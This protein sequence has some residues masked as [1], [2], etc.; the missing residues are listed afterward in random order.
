MKTSSIVT[1]DNLVSAVNDQQELKS[2]VITNT[3]NV[4][5]TATTPEAGSPFN[6]LVIQDS[7]FHREFDTINN[8][9]HGQLA[10]RLKIP[11]PYYDRMPPELR[12]T[13]VNHWLHESKEKRL[14][15]CLGNT[16]RA[17][18]SNSYYCYDHIDILEAVLPVLFEFPNMK[19]LSCDITDKKLYL[20]VGFEGMQLEVAPG[21]V[22]ESGVIISNSE[23]GAGSA[24]VQPYLNRLWCSNG[25]W[26]SEYGQNKA[27]LGSRISNSDK[28]QEIFSD[29]TKKKEKEA[30]SA[31]MADT[32]RACIDET[33]FATIV[34]DFKSKMDVP[35]EGDVIE[36]IEHV[37]KKLNLAEFET[38]AALNHLL[39]APDLEKHRN[40]GFGII[41]AITRTAEDSDS[42]DRATE[43]EK[44]GGDLSAMDNADFNRL[45]N[46]VA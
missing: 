7:N 6:Q 26:S 44:I 16:V 3:A 30:T 19:I 21:D 37:G 40:N 31:I 11:K 17:V 39:T 41:N 2:D 18:V 29:D 15:R 28:A 38:K 9:A 8:H 35:I 34:N 42:Y 13:N 20:K 4:T 10:N 45:L 14:F 23:V 25:C 12:A 5:M 46:K 36:T 43:L 1:L 27:H 22:V 33:K 24:I 32:V